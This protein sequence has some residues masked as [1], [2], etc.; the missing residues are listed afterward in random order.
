MVSMYG[1]LSMT[2]QAIEEVNWAAMNSGNVLRIIS[3]E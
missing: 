1:P 2:V 3:H